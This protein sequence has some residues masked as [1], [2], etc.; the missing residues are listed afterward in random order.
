MNLLVR[1]TRRQEGQGIVEYALMIGLVVLVIWAVVNGSGVATF[2]N[3][4]WDDVKA[5]IEAGPS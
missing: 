5:G 1:L 4:T 3:Q 2:I